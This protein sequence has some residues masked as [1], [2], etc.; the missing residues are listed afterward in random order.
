MR[1]TVAMTIPADVVARVRLAASRDRKA[2]PALRCVLVERVGDVVRAVA[3]DRHRLMVAERPA[4]AGDGD[5]PR[6]QL[7]DPETG[8]AAPEPAAD[9]P[10]YERFLA[11]DD[12]AASATVSASALLA[13]VEAAVDDDTPLAV[14]VDGG[15]V[16]VGEDVETPTL[17]VDPGYLHDALEAAA[18]A[19]VVVE[20]TGPM[21]AL[22]IRAPGLLSLVMPV[23]VAN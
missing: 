14:Q 18:G 5:G 11:A 15:T 1:Y 4:A 12:G 8:E 10:D 21:A 17:H 16:R 23:R 20:A 19:Q 2:P 7:V 13:A 9:F 22:A 3:T 6:R